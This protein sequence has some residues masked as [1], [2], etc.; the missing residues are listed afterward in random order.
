MTTRILPLS[1]IHVDDTLNVSRG[2]KPIRETPSLFALAEDIKAS[3]QIDPVG[4]V[5]L[6]GALWLTEEERDRLAVSGK[7]YVLI[8]GFRRFKSCSIIEFET[9]RCQDLGKATRADAELENL[10]EN[11]GREPPTDY[12]LTLACFRCATQHTFPTVTIARR[13]NKP[14][15]WVEDSIAIVVNIAPDLLDHYRANCGV[16]VRRK[17]MQLLAIDGETQEIKHEHQRAQ[18]KQWEIEEAQARTVDPNADFQRRGPSRAHRD[19]DTNVPTRTQLITA[20]D[21]II[22]GQ[23]F[24]DGNKWRPMTPEVLGAL[25]S[26]ARWTLNPNENFP[27]K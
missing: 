15:K 12:D 24:Y 8:Y 26:F 22:V 5:P 2:G 14:V 10:A 27:V 11:C 25:R 3:G 23:H 16:P 21:A 6:A 20:A 18:W 13:V 4:V 17:M 7:E 19:R 9:I 1:I